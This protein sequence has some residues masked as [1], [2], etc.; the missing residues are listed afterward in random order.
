MSKAINIYIAGPLFSVAEREFN[1]RM[2]GALKERVGN[3]IVILP[4]EY[5]STV[6]GTP[7]FLEKVFDHSLKSI[8]KSDV[9]VAILDGPDVDAGTCMEIGYAYA[10]KKP[11]IGVRTDFRA[12][13]DRGVNLMVSK[14]CTQ[15][16]WPKGSF[17]TLE[18]VL[19]ETAHAVEALFSTPL[20]SGTDE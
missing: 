6:V 4:Q 12:S 5:A 11:I 14:A 2:A 9:V 16:L 1:R 7:G 17:H 20:R 19:H 15:L 3:C 13:E 8:R 18:S 10:N